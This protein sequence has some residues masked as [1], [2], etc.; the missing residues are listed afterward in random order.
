M[1]LPVDLHFEPDLGGDV[2]ESLSASAL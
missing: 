1:S 2:L